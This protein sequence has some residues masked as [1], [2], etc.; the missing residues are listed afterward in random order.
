MNGSGTCGSV[1]NDAG[2][3]ILTLNLDTLYIGGGTSGQPPSVVPDYYLP[4]LFKVGSCGGGSLTLTN[5]TSTDTG[6]SRSCTSTGCSYGPPV[7]VVNPNPSL[8]VCVLN[9]LSSNASGSLTCGSGASH[10]NIP[11]GA[12]T[13][14]TGD[15]MFNRCGAGTTNPDDVGRTCSTDA[16]CGGA[17]GSCVS[18]TAHTQ[19]CP[20]CNATTSKCNGGAKDVTN[21]TPGVTVC[22]DSTL[23]P[24]SGICPAVS[25]SPGTVA[26][27][28]DPFPTSLDCPPAA[29]NLIATLPIA[30]ALDTGTTTKTGVLMNNIGTANDQDRVFC[31]FCADNSTNCAS[32]RGSLGR[33][34]NWGNVDLHAD[35]P[36]RLTEHTKIRLAADLFNLTDM[37]TQLVWP[38]GGIFAY[39]GG[40]PVNENAATVFC[41]FQTGNATIDTAADLPGPGAACVK[42][43]V[44]LLP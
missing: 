11:L 6:S 32:A 12:G 37:R 28:G 25:C 7:P 21:C 20:I 44:Q 8:S 18:D 3:S 41:I 35:Y 34:K 4:A 39:S 15:I 29:I 43:A 30:Y 24:G 42:G 26:S 14:L 10:L 2:A 33:T 31:G 22:P 5:A 36:I 23:C 9:T 1:K 17:V 16:N 13:Y 19:P 40:A 38:L 27:S